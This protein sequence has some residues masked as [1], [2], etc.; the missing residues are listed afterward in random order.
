MCLSDDRGQTDP[1][2]AAG[3]GRSVVSPTAA[4][5]AAMPSEPVRDDGYFVLSRRGNGGASLLSLC[6]AAS[7]PARGLVKRLRHEYALR[8]ELNSAWAVRPSDFSEQDGG[9]AV[10]FLEDPGGQ[11]ASSLVG[12][13]LDIAV[14][15]RVAIGV[16]ASVGRAHE[17]GM[18]H[19]DL[20]PAN[21]LTD[22][23]TGR[24]WLMGFGLASRLPRKRRPLDPPQVIEGTLAY[25]TP[26]QTGRMNRS[27]D[28]RS[29][30]YSL[31]VTPIRA[32]HGEAAIRGIRRYRLESASLP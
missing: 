20:K 29:D 8:Q 9:P 26:E 18:V 4:G 22:P 1:D 11:L 15:L 31:G 10:M 14:L 30:L 25:M 12:Q 24:A 28:T 27:V 13:P 16:A 17:R 19:R 5:D 7:H 23:A 3:H 2:V 21:L 32:L 6:V